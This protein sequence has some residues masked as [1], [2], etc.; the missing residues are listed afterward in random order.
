MTEVYT[1]RHWSIKKW[2]HL[3]PSL[4]RCETA[5]PP[6]EFC[7]PVGLAPW[8][9]PPAPPP[10]AVWWGERSAATSGLWSSGSDNRAPCAGR[11]PAGPPGRR[12]HSLTSRACFTCTLTEPHLHWLGVQFSPVRGS[13]N[14]LGFPVVLLL[15]VLDKKSLRQRD[16]Q[17]ERN[18]RAKSQRNPWRLRQL[19]QLI[20]ARSK[21]TFFSFVSS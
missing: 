3:P 6:Q 2:N 16:R 9:P 5:L 15:F 17:R 14:V 11:S 10:S 18:G 7:S 1:S 13:T 12:S 4:L 19:Q 21:A 8:T 20:R